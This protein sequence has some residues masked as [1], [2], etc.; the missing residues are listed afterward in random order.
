MKMLEANPVHI[1]IALC[2]S[3]LSGFY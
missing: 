1:I 3:T 2:A